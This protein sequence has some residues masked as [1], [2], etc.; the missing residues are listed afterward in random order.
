MQ[1]ILC[2]IGLDLSLH[3][4]LVHPQL[5]DV[6]G[7]KVNEDRGQSLT[8]FVGVDE[9]LVEFLQLL[10]ECGM[11]LVAVGQLLVHV[12]QFLMAAGQFPTP[13]RQ[14][15]VLLVNVIG[16]EEQSQHQQ[17]NENDRITQFLILGYNSGLIGV[18]DL[19]KCAR[20][21]EDAQTVVVELGILHRRIDVEFCPRNLFFA[22]IEQA[23]G[24]ILQGEVFHRA[25]LQVAHRR[26]DHIFYI[27]I[28]FSSH[29][30]IARQCK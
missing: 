15:T 20:D 18:H 25:V 11:R 16:R 8:T 23:N 17:G 4:G 13:R 21:F 1:Q 6:F 10:V 12:D 28:L 27:F 29:P 9:L 2:L 26:L 22:L 5:V 24:Q 30:I 3:Q 7:T 14:L 19:W